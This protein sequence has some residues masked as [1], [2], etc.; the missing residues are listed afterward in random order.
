M[1]IF[2]LLIGAISGGALVAVFFQFN[3]KTASDLTDVSFYKT[4]LENA[5]AET[6]AMRIRVESLIDEKAT[7]DPGVFECN[8]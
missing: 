4:E 1:D 2:S 6:A 7:T 3:R 8:E 5:K